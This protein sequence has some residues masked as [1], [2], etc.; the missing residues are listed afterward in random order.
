MTTRFLF[1]FALLLSLPYMASAASTSTTLQ[2]ADVVT[3]LLQIDQELTEFPIFGKKKTSNKKQLKF[4]SKRSR[5]NGK[6]V[7]RA[8]KRR[9]SNGGRSVKGGQRGKRGSK[10]KEGCN[11]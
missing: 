5:R 3:D 10:K 1:A 6:G 2:E 9:G 4:A 11:T 8:R 7:M